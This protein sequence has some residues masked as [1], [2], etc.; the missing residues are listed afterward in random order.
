[1]YRFPQQHMHPPMHKS[2]SYWHLLQV[3]TH[4]KRLQ[5][6]RSHAQGLTAGVTGDP[7]KSH[8]TRANHS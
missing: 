4:F 2:Y 8:V 7:P 6:H 5:L 1:M 3:P